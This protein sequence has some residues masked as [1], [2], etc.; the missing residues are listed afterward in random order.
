MDN[1]EE[2]EAAIRVAKVAG[3]ILMSY[4]DR[5]NVEYKA[6]RS[7]V[8][9]A[10][11]ESEKIIKSILNEEFPDYSF[12]GEESG[13][14][15]KASDYIWVVDPLDGTTNYTIRDPFFNVSVGLTYKGEPILGVVYYPYEKELFQAE[16]EKGAYLNNEKIQVSK[17]E[18]LENSVV[19]F[20]HHRDEASIR[21][22]GDIFVAVKLVTNRFRQIGAGGLELSYVA[23]GRTES[24][25]MPGA[26]TWDVVAGAIIVKEAGGM[27]TDF[28]GMPYTMESRDIL[29]SNGR[30]H[31]QL[32]KLLEGL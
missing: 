4:Y 18:K 14:E 6:D 11:L 27:V 2:M 29:A 12:L 30:I 23:C 24:F 8:T 32:L 31:G 16:K 15:E 1:S 22:M 17:K 9:E 5:I 21:R 28:E 20:C 19:T 3:K 10:D 13:L 25:M 7:V 26:N